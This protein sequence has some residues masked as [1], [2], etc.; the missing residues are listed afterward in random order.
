MPLGPMPRAAA[1]LAKTCFQF[2]KLALL[3]PQGAAATEPP[4][5]ASIAANAAAPRKCV[6]AIKIPQVTRLPV[7]PFFSLGRSYL[8]RSLCQFYRRHCEPDTANFAG[9]P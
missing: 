2:S 8:A 1:S 5:T 6:F 9:T 4:I 3:L 7:T